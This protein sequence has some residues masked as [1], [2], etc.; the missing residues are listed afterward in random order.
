MD[1]IKPPK[2][3]SASKAPKATDATG[4]AK[5]TKSKMMLRKVNQAHAAKTDQKLPPVDS[6]PEPITIPIPR[7]MLA[8]A[9]PEY[10]EESDP[11][12]E[13]EDDEAYL[14]T[15][16]TNLFEDSPNETK[17]NS[18][19]LSQPSPN[20]FYYG[21]HYRAS[22]LD[23]FGKEG[24]QTSSLTDETT[25]MPKQELKTTPAPAKAAPC[26]SSHATASTAAKA[27][28]NMDE[29]NTPTGEYNISLS[30][31]QAITDHLEL[32]EEKQAAE[33]KEQA[34]TLASTSKPQGSTTNDTPVNGK[35]SHL[36]LPF[37]SASKV[38]TKGHATTAK[39]KATP[40]RKS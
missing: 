2:G 8:K 18:P 29:A 15:H 5:R 1:S 4:S 10:P 40:T 17:P 3:H 14:S 11:D 19:L 12:P 22:L 35:T 16:S 23:L 37:Q 20:D 13:E 24:A 26:K 7:K 38:L 30:Q 36:V 39:A 31:E 21:S 28:E 33:L 27:L 34:T 9:Q 25:P 6:A 32:L